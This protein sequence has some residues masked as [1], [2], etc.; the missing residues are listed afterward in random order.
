MTLAT[1]S[2]GAPWCCNLF[3]AYMPDHEAL[4]FT[5]PV[6]SRHVAQILENDRVAASI[7]LES[8]VVGR[9][10]G[11]QIEG[12][13]V[14]ATTDPVLHG[15]ARGAYLRRFPYAAAMLADLW[16]LRLDTLKYT[17][18]TL[19][20]GTKLHWSATPLSADSG[21]TSPNSTK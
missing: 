15:N 11:L 20:F 18:N 12:R 21:T 4:V 5:S 3:Y 7:L 17:D 1:V 2:A 8:R 14:N 16:V 6:G 9:L 13:V 10:Q 19:G